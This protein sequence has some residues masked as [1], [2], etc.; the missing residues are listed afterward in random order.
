MGHARRLFLLAPLLGALASGCSRAGARSERGGT[1]VMGI[2]S[3]L[4]PGTDLDRL[5]VTMRAAGEI[6]RED[7]LSAGGEGPA[8]RLPTELRFEDLPDST[9]VD[10]SLEA[11]EGY[12]PILS[13]LASTRIVAGKTLLL[14][15]WLQRECI[16]SYRLQAGVV[17]P[18]CSPP[19]TCISAACKDP[20]VP[21][22][23][24]EEYAPS[25]ATSFADACKPGG[26]AAPDV[27]IGQGE[28]SYHPLSDGDAMIFEKGPQGGLH[29]WVA[30][31]MRNLHQKGSITTIS[32]YFPDLGTAFG[33]VEVG[34]GY[35][36]A[37]DGSCVLHGLRYVIS[38]DVSD[39]QKLVGTKLRL[40]VKVAD[41]TGA[42]GSDETVVTLTN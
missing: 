20:F 7:T 37:G 32:A 26:D 35:D 33:D 25:W 28:T 23:E 16:P 40:D 11:I 38:D 12:G 14:R 1:V 31:G 27:A 2:M 22:T 18:T 5:H 39:F 3:D 15:V 30:V 21:P 6:V 10:V 36:T 9:A 42:V 17:S 19:E 34:Y 29:V 13:R 41:I 4:E 8:L 24:L